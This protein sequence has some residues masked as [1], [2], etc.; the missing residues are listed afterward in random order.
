MNAPKY[1][2]LMKD[3][4]NDLLQFLEDD[5]NNEENFQNLYN[6]CTNQKINENLHMLKSIL[7]LITKITN[8][9]HRNSLF[10]N[11]I[12]QVLA[13]FKDDIKK[14]F[15]NSE[16][17]NIFRNNKRILLFLIEE[18]IMNINACIAKKISLSSK[19]IKGDY[20]EYFSPELQIYKIESWFK[21]FDLNAKL[22]EY[23][24]EK[25]KAGEND[26]KI[27]E[28][29]REDL[30]EEFI[31]FV[32]KNNYPLNSVIQKCT[33]ETNSILVR[34]KVTLIEYS[35]F[36]GSIQIFRY[37][38]LNNVKL[39]LSLFIYA[40]HGQNPEI[41][42]ILEDNIKPDSDLYMKYFIR[43]IKCHHNDIAN[44]FWNNFLSD[45]EENS[46]IKF[47]QCLKYY[48][49]AFIQDEYINRSFFIYFCKYDYYFLVDFLLNNNDIDIN[50]LIIHE[51]IIQSSFKY[52]IILHDLNQIYQ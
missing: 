10:Y 49:F 11:K 39:T 45:D 52:Y 27:C 4:Q 42:H 5:E 34:K 7:H 38:M 22:P 14:Y 9:H 28:L 37:L 35:A 24:Y 20:M 47:I 26:N 8:G 32:N 13:I 6:I 48:N 21:G 19:Y 17:F 43:S 23:F 46:K 16:I 41:I 40:I 2:T 15:T 25:R 3:I 33:Y 51:I 30:I 12:D 36:F 50:Q 44:Y 18:K 31:I 1:L 29:I